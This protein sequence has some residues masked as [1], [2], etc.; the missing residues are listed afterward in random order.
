MVLPYRSRSTTS[1]RTRFD[2]RPVPRACAPWHCTQPVAYVFRPR[3]AAASS[4]MCL[5]PAPALASSP[6]GRA[7]RAGGAA[8]P[9][10]WPP[11]QS[12]A[13]RSMLADQIGEHD[14]ALVG[15]ERRTARGHHLV[16][17]FL[18][19]R[20]RAFRR[21]HPFGRVAEAALA[22]KD[23][24]RLRARGR[25]ACLRC[26]WLLRFTDQPQRQARYRRAD[27]GSL[28]HTSG[29]PE[30]GN[31]RYTDGSYHTKAPATTPTCRNCCH[32]PRTGFPA[33]V[34]PKNGY[35]GSEYPG[36]DGWPGATSEST[37]ASSASV[38]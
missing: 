30:R 18:P 10:R 8:P 2:P 26:W 12:A 32:A 24:S 35:I 22:E 7:A 27:Q 16:D 3:A 23:V 37:S 6:R 11:R 4:T 14:L 33:R 34:R 21:S 13:P 20:L 17:G 15:G 5:S 31:P 36:V 19:L 1:E 29:P 25:R 9:A 38:H 28:D